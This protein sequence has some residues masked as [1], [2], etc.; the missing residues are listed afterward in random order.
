MPQNRQAGSL[1]YF[2]CHTSLHAANILPLVQAPS[3]IPVSGRIWRIRAS[4]Y[5]GL[6]QLERV[7]KIARSGDR[8]YSGA[9]IDAF[10]AGRVPSRGAFVDF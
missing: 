5:Q 4:F 8:A 1:P 3:G 10:P 9:S 7:L 2:P 6:S